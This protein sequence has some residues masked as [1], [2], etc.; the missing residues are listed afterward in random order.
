MAAAFFGCVCLAVLMGMLTAAI[1][2]QSRSCKKEDGRLK[3]AAQD[4]HYHVTIDVAP[5]IDPIPWEEDHQKQ[6]ASP[7]VPKYAELCAA[8]WA[9]LDEEDLQPHPKPVPASDQRTAWLEARQGQTQNGLI[10]GQDRCGAIVDIMSPVVS[11]VA[12]VETVQPLLLGISRGLPTEM[13]GEASDSG[14][15]AKTPVPTVCETTAFLTSRVWSSQKIGQEEVTTGTHL[16]WSVPSVPQ[17]LKHT[18]K[19]GITDV[20]QRLRLLSG[21]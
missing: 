19:Q 5:I 21:R 3:D 2:S 17:S 8:I 10:S 13:S 18:W 1:A 7:K 20:A 11:P 15:C 9:T 12:Q 14:T 6:D 16:M 4:Q